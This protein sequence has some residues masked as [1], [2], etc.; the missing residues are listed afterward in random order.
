MLTLVLMKDFLLA[1]TGLLA[2]A[3]FPLQYWLDVCFGHPCGAGVANLK[4]IRKHA[5][6]PNLGRW[7]FDQYFAPV[8]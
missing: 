5:L 8:L 6:P 2:Y 3:R 1:C 7:P 4:A